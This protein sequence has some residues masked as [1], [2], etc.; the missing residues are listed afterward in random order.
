M[1][2]E[3]S[4]RKVNAE[5][6]G[7][8][9]WLRRQ[10]HDRFRQIDSGFITLVDA[11]GETSFGDPD[12]PPELRARVEVRDPAL[13]SAAA[14]AGALGAAESFM[15][16]HWEADDL[17]TVIR[18][19]V[20]NKHVLNSMER[21]LARLTAPLLKRLHRRNRNTRDGSAR[22][23][24]A[25]YDLGNEFFGL[26]LDRNMMYSSA[27]YQDP[28]ETLE[29]ASDRK[30]DRICRKLA[31][32]PG[33][34]VLEIGT[35]WGGF[36]VFAATRYGCHVTTTT[37]SREQHAYAQERVEKAGL[38]DRITLLKK[39]Y[40]DLT[41]RYDK[42]VSIEM[43]EA[44]GHQYLDTYITQCS[45]LLKD[46]GAFLLQAITIADHIY[47]QALKGVDFIQRYIFPGSFIPAVSAICD[48]AARVS[49][50]RLFH[51]EDIG[52]SYA[53]TLREWRRRFMSRLDEVRAM[54]YPESFIRMWEYY[55]CYCEGGFLERSIGDAQMLFT[56]PLNR[57]ESLVPDL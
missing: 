48:S 2:T 45:Q 41:G 38:S 43:I 21:G 18:V 3:I 7:R 33:D 1:T 39:D 40:R 20:R 12:A 13:Y 29:K 9:S 31:L 11:W 28:S 34:E 30:L 56:K 6:R 19:L 44:V 25:H 10:V 8:G 16:G 54:G 15:D 35:G 24:A 52:P 27:V 22:N 46:D 53:L 26:F 14:F 42:L 5:G 32:K 49:D 23:I 4:A 37:I 57:R 17:T 55:L 50:M 51:L 47:P 36:A